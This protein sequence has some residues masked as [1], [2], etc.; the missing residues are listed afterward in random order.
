MEY[1][2]TM[3][4]MGRNRGKNWNGIDRKKLGRNWEKTVKKMGR[5]VEK[6]MEVF[7][8]YF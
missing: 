6:K 7:P 1:E 4:E 8:I 3:N 2:E 5:N